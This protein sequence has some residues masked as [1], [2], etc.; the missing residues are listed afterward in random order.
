MLELAGSWRSGSLF[1]AA[2]VAHLVAH[3]GIFL[4]LLIPVRRWHTRGEDITT[5]VVLLVVLL[6]ATG[7]GWE[8]LR[9]LLVEREPPPPAVML[10][11]LLGLAANVTTAYLFKY[12]AETRWSFRAAVAHE[13][14]DAM[15]TVAGLVGALSI[16]LFGFRW[17]DPALSIA[18][19]VWLALWATRLLA[20]R[21]RL[22]PA[23]WSET[24][25]VPSTSDA[26][27]RSRPV[28]APGSSPP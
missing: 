26:R 13:L 24:G 19:A 9:A 4:V 21:V 15:L 6:I 28:S 5:N 1:L 3:V 27:E 2:D 12:A 10:L 23:T 17:V 20:R 8:S 14:S 7:I 25:R 18:I 22:G 16:A 11:S